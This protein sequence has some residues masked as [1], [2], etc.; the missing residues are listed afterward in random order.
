[1]QATVSRDSCSAVGA[2]DEGNARMSE[3][4]LEEL[5]YDECLERLRQRTVGR[6]AIVV[7]DAPAV[8][9]VNYRLVETAGLTFLALR[10]RPGNIVDR[11]AMLVAFEIDEIDEARHVGWSVLVRGTLHRVDPEAADFRGRFD[12]QPWLADERDAWLLV[13]PF[14]ITG[15]RLERATPEWA[16]DARAYM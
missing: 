5:S 12:S 10:T 1:M 2:T 13:Q 15:R 9:P 4:W 11:A 7:D 14:A 6:I 16:F 3:T 8:M